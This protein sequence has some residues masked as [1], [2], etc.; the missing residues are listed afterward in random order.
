MIEQDKFHW[1]LKWCFKN[2]VLLRLDGE[3]GI[4]RK[5]VGIVAMPGMYPDYEWYDEDAQLI[6]DGAEI[7]TPERA[8]H[9]HPCVAVLGQDDESVEQLFQWLCWFDKN[10]YKV[11]TGMVKRRDRFSEVE[12]LLNKHLYARMVRK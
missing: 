11:E 9:K 1:M 6:G 2:K 7:W 3:C 4:G 8:Y 12:L 5:C 10:G